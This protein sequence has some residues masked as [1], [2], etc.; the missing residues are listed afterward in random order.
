MFYYRLFRKNILHSPFCSYIHGL[1]RVWRCL[2]F[3]IQRT[4][5]P[6]LNVCCSQCRWCL[7]SGIHRCEGWRTRW[8]RCADTSVCIERCRESYPI[9][10]ERWR[11]EACPWVPDWRTPFRGGA[12][13]WATWHE[14]PGIVAKKA[15]FSEEKRAWKWLTS[16]L[17]TAR[18]RQQSSCPRP[19]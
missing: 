13:W 4:R 1:Q 9:C 14:C 3:S 7:V 18:I 16:R 15:L 6:W 17:S 8:Q 11:C 12:Q 10:W 19:Y 2:S 5:F